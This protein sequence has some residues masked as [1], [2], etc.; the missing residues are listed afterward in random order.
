MIIAAIVAITI[1][2]MTAIICVRSMTADE[3]DILVTIAA[4]AISYLTVMTIIIWRIVG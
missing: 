1:I 4:L 3:T 2:I